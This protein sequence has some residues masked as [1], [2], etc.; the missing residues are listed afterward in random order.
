MKDAFKGEIECQKQLGMERKTGR[1]E[2][3][4]AI[5]PLCLEREI[6]LLLKR[7]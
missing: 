1:E 4:Q 2:T 6:I 5:C 3:Q 7:R